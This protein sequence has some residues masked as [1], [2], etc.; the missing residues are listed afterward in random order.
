MHV[1]GT[2]LASIKPGSRIRMKK[3]TIVLNSG[4]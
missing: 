4:G 1:A 3:S 2:V